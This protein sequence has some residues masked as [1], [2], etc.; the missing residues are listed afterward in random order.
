MS[1]NSRVKQPFDADAKVTLRD[2]ADGAETATATE[3][4]IALDAIEEPGV[5]RQL[6]PRAA[7]RQQAAAPV[8]VGPHREPEMKMPRLAS[9]VMARSVRNIRLRRCGGCMKMVHEEARTRGI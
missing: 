8:I 2:A 7:A 5:I 1:M 3:A 9:S 4:G 6:L